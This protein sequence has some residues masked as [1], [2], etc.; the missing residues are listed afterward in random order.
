METIELSLTSLKVP[1][2]AIGI[3]LGQTLTKIAYLKNEKL[4]LTLCERGN[5]EKALN[6]L[7][8]SKTPAYKAI[9]LTGGKAY[10]I[11]RDYSH[12]YSA[13]LINEFQAIVKGTETLYQLKLQK[14]LQDAVIVSLGTGTSIT[15]KKK[16]TF[17]H[18][19]GS[20]LG[21][22]FFNG[23]N[24]LF[25]GETEYS[26]LLK[27]AKQGNRCNVD[28]KVDDIYHPDDNRVDTMF[29]EFTAASLGKIGSEKS[30]ENHKQV[31]IIQ[32]I[33]NSIGET[34]GTIACLVAKNEDIKEII[35]IG[36]FLRQNFILKQILKIICQINNKRAI[37]IKHSEY[38]GSI[39]AL[40]V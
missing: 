27:M 36:G 1:E 25:F 39:G 15:L 7:L 32:S 22:A 35:F 29:R 4:V 31:D 13:T 33:L 24:E 18:V 37:F 5:Q 26:D 28:L 21:G 23:L 20:A 38:A 6:T 10:E 30:K 16:E 8:N 12:R 34:I 3:D 14:T 17:K 40:L 19:T 2:N 9:K 11:F